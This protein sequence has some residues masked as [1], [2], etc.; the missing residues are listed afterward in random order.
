MQK[1]KDK[2]KPNPHE[3]ARCGQAIKSDLVDPPQEPEQRNGNRC[4]MTQAGGE[5]ITPLEK[6]Q[7][8]KDQ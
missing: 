5:Q 7:V 8:G 2:A 6:G 3:C 1:P 4:D